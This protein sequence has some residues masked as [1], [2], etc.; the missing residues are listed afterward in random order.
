MRPALYLKL[1]RRNMY[2]KDTE[3][4]SNLNS[5]FEIL[6]ILDLERLK[7]FKLDF[8]NNLSQYEAI[9]I[10]DGHDY[11]KKLG[12]MKARYERLKAIINLIETFYS[13]QEDIIL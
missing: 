7:T 13:T 11:F 3:L 9:G 5:L 12:N 4:A 1:R 8:E 2:D 6:S 10:I